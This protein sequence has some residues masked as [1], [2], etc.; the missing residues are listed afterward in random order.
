M[1][2]QTNKKLDHLETPNSIW[3]P[4]KHEHVTACLRDNDNCKT[5]LS[6]VNPLYSAGKLGPSLVTLADAVACELDLD[7][8]VGLVSTKSN[9]PEKFNYFN[10]PF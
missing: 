4:Y 2:N 3:R 5:Y 10:L 6:F 7:G 8:Y 9:P 1:Y